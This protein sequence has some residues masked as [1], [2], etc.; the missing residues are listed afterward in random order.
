MGER[1]VKIILRGWYAVDLYREGGGSTGLER[2]EDS[3]PG[4]ILSFLE[5]SFYINLQK[6]LS[7][8]L[9]FIS[10]R[11]LQFYNKFLG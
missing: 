5:N 3:L 4:G 10:R 8:P 1:R 9:T 6:I 11:L 2:Y 7:Q